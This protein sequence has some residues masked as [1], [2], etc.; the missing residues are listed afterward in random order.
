MRARNRVQDRMPKPAYDVDKWD[1]KNLTNLNWFLM[2]AIVINGIQC[3]AVIGLIFYVL[4]AKHKITGA[5]PIFY[6]HLVLLVTSFVALI[7][8]IFLKKWAA[9]LYIVSGIMIIGLLSY[10]GEG[11]KAVWQLMHVVAMI[12]AVKSV[13][14]PAY[15]PKHM[16][17]VI[18]K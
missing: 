8:L 13:W 11:G 14:K 15:I 6:I 3:L 16:K 7:F 12:M 17:E 18:D 4:V 10:L 9:I 2:G 1:P 5:D